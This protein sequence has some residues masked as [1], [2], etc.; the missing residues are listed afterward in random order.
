M[1]LLDGIFDVGCNAIDTAAIYGLGATE[2]LIGKWMSSRKLR[3]RLFLITKGAPPGVPLNFN[4]RVI[5]ADLHRSLKRLRTDHVDLFMLHRDDPSKP[6]E[7]V[8]AL[9]ARF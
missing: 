2:R 9:L 3:D 4:T 1:R 7:N 6:F 5:S 8:L